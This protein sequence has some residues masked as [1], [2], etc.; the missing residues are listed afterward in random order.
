MHILINLYHLFSLANVKPSYHIFRT[1]RCIFSGT[2][3]LMRSGHYESPGAED[4]S[5]DD[6]TMSHVF[7]VQ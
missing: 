3:L 1:I 7:N 5:D 6:P 2:E 4:G